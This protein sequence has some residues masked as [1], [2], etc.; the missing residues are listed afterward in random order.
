MRI[1]PFLI[2]NFLFWNTNAQ[3]DGNTSPTYSELIQTYK[4]LADEHDE[5]E[6]FSMGESDYGL[7]I[8]LC[9]LNG[10]QDSL[11]TF[12]KAKNST[13]ILV[14]N[15]IHP[16]EP[17]GINA[18]L[19]FINNWIEDG[20]P[21]KN[22]PVIGI[23]PSYNVGGTVNRSSTSRANQEGPE[24]YGFRGNAQ[25][26]DLN[27]DFIKMDSKNMFVFAKI[28]HGLDPDVFIDTHVSNGA[29]YQYT[30][31]YIASVK[32]R[33]APSIRS[34]VYEYMIPEMGNKLN[35]RD[36]DW[37]PYVNLK[38]AVP[39]SGITVFN[40]L[41]RYS[42]GY[43]SLFHTI[44]FTVETH[45]LKPFDQRAKATLK[46]LEECVNWTSKNPVD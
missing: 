30:L 36:C 29:D 1:L 4:K 16:G 8:Y 38:A 31:T 32:E 6:F 24:E 23:I 20:K 18:C 39:D 28:F 22:M 27:R 33:M 10:E 17:D 25:N 11:F 2:F 43:T 34:I 5:I 9:V 41:P 45:M 37:V 44:S 46:F 42:M 3:V 21:T 35:K 19:T 40:D 7:P 26:L 14:N 12:G 13:T 15:G